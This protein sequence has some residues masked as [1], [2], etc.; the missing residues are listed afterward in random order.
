MWDVLGTGPGT[1]QPPDGR[2]PQA[3]LTDGHSGL[4]ADLDIVSGK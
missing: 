3:L 1:Q 2:E 4:F